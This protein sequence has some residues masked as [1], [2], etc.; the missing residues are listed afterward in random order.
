MRK[1]RGITLI[2]LII[3]IIILLILVGVSVNLLIKGDLFGSA[4]K[5]VNGTNAKVEEQQNRVDDLMGRLEDVNKKNAT[6]NWQYTN[7][8]K[9]QIRCTCT[10]CQFSEYGDGNG[11]TLSV[12]QQLGD[13]EY[14]TAS[15][16]ITSE[17]SGYAIWNSTTQQAEPADQTIE[18]DNEETKWVVFGYED[19]NGDGL[20]ETLLL[21]TEHPTEDLVYFGG[22][23]GYNNGIEEVNRM[24]KE[25]Y[26]SNARGITIE[27]VDRVLGFKPTGGMYSMRG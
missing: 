25:I 1:N 18:L 20:N 10:T 2:A 17:R 11:R 21:T 8:T 14:I 26:G 6:H 24:C 22:S 16:S 4:E 19:K 15:T 5:A 9:A 13:T 12:G 7:S 3:T 23:S 27:D